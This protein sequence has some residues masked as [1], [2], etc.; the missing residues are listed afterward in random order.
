M[1]LDCKSDNIFALQNGLFGNA[2][3]QWQTPGEV[4]REF[5]NRPIVV[6]PRTPGGRCW[7]EIT[8][9][10][11]LALPGDIRVSDYYF[12]EPIDPVT[13]TLNAEITRALLGGV[14]MTYATTQEHMRPALRNH[15]R[16]ARRIEALIIL[17]TLACERGREVV[18]G[19]MD[20]YPDHVIEFTCMT[21]SYGTLGWKTVVWEVRSY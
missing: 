17:R 19:L 16:H 9:E 1:R 11:W 21:K 18:E 20:Q 8:I 12:N 3:K 2:P 6:R 4:L 5:G 7:Y 10:E 15:A 13:V 14:A